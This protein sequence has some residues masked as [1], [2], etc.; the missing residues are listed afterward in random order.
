MG[1]PRATPRAGEPAATSKLPI[2]ADEDGALTDPVQHALVTDLAGRNHSSRTYPDEA[3]TRVC[4][5]FD[6]DTEAA[7]MCWPAARPR[8]PTVTSL[9]ASSRLT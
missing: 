6:A 4:D 1:Q 2:S 5:V 3:T 8:L 9:A 7:R